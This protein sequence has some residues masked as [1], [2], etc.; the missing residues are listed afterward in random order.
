MD[1]K[2]YF[3]PSDFLRIIHNGGW[4]AFEA[5]DNELLDQI[6][7]YHFK[8][9]NQMRGDVGLPMRVTGCFR[10]VLWER[11]RGRSGDSQHTFPEH[12]YHEGVGATDCEPWNRTDEN[13]DTFIGMGNSYLN[14]YQRTCFY[15]LEGFFHSD[16]KA[17]MKQ[18]FVCTY[19]Y[20]EEREIWLQD[21]WE[22]VE[23][24]DDWERL[25]KEQ[26]QKF[27]QA[28]RKR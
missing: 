12:E 28:R 22:Y 6:F 11:A 18:R 27:E 23:D 26:W 9:Q 1:N 4:H 10:P 13:P 7:E 2:Y 20:D 16:Y 25:I 21:S 5:K 15:P 3:K 17:K 8:P 24:H 19:K 14:Y